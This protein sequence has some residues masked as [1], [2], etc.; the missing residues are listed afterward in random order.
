MLELQDVGMT[1]GTTAALAD[2]HLQLGP[3]EVLAVL[4]PSGCGKTT[5]LRV[6]AGLEPHHTG[7][8]LWNSTDVTGIPPHR[9]R[10]GLVFQSYALFPH[11][12][13]AG[14]V[15]FGLEVTG[16]SAV[17]TERLT[18]DALRLVRLEHL[19]DRRISD[20]S[21][22]EQQRVALARALAPRPRMLMFDEPLGALDREL[23]ER[24]LGELIT[25]LAETAVPA[26]YVTHDQEEAL[27]V[28]HRVAVMRR[29]RIVQ[30]GTPEQVW[31]HPADEFV[32]GFVGFT[33]LTPYRRQGT[34]AVTIWG[35]FDLPASSPTDG[36]AAARPD[37]VGLSPDGPL[38]ATVTEVVFRGGRWDA[39]LRLADG[40]VLRASLQQRPT[41]ATVRCA[42]DPQATVFLPRT[43]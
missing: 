33:N 38:E 12:S 40:T 9:R 31:Q 14:N 5:L 34:R 25:L 21:G 6:V 43:P 42:V 30:I 2:V 10:F 32:A 20:L 17:E 16:A 19:A 41:T 18:A 7:R 4:G 28:G 1:F 26:V 29:G 11:R 39:M 24:L 37:A 13:V 15:A 22:G 8:V 23:R 36:L 35:D 3:S 27:A